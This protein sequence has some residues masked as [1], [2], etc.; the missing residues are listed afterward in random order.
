MKSLRKF[1]ADNLGF[2]GAEK[3]LITL[4]ALGLIIIVARYV[5][6]GSQAA[7]NT[8][9]GVLTNQAA[10]KNVDFNSAEPTTGTGKQ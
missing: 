6:L 1:F 9:Q 3:A 8:N 4:L 2:T 5:L 7:S 10:P